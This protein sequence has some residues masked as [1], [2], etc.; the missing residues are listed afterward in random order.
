NSG[1][2]AADNAK[3][4]LDLAGVQYENLASRQLDLF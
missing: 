1:G 3:Q 2:D 4:Y